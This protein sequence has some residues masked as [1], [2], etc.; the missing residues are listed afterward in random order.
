M[1]F[2]RIP[3]GRAPEHPVAR[4]T[5]TSN[6]E[7]ADWNRQELGNNTGAH[8]KCP[9][10]GNIAINFIDWSIGTKWYQTRCYSCGAELQANG[11]TI[12][13]VI[14]TVVLGVI[15][16]LTYLWMADKK[17]I[18]VFY[19]LIAAVGFGGAILTWY[20]VGGYTATGN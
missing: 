11:G 14:L 12:T 13:G 10:C 4:Q 20:T 6:Q 17:Q 9:T 2:H 3:A 19:S 5:L 16:G 8:M 7:Y 15:A 18:A 1:N